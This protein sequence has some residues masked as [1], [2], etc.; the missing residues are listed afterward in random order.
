MQFS[1]SCSHTIIDIL[2][3]A[4]GDIIMRKLIKYFLSKLGLLQVASKLRAVVVGFYD[5]FRFSFRYRRVIH[6]LKKREGRK[7]RVLFVVN[8]I[9]KWKCQALFEIMK[10]SESYEPII[11]LSA[12]NE[13]GML[14]DAEIEK[15]FKRAESFFAELGDTCIRTVSLFPRVY[16][17][18][19]E[20]NTD[21]VFY[22]EPWAPCPGQT[23]MEVSQ[24]AL[25]FYIPYY[26]PNY[27]NVKFDCHD[28]VQ[29]FCFAFI[30][31]NV[32]WKNCYESSFGMFG[33]VCKFLPFG[34]P[35]MDLIARTNVRFKSIGRVIY[36]PHFSFPMEGYPLT[37]T[38]SSFKWSGQYML[39]YAKLHPEQNWVF[40]PH[41]SL[42]RRLQVTGY[43]TKDQ[44]DAYYG[45]WNKIGSIC[46]DGAYHKLFAESSV[47]ITDS[48]SFLTEYGAT[49]KPLIR[50][51]DSN[52]NTPVLAPSK[53]LY[54]TY[55]EAHNLDELK[56][57]L[58][59]ILDDKL[60]PKKEIRTIAALRANLLTAD[61]SRTI[62]NYID[63][64]IK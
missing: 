7:V 53:K 61:A 42:R 36:A 58:S 46:M 30:T 26:V 21:I 23:P 17:R 59:M 56:R 43:M 25:T 49:G 41:P 10:K 54:D 11:A 35:A 45:E 9:A 27:G 64:L 5:L 47:M 37:F 12:W 2:R 55:Y 48:A 13:I 44:I 16:H 29:R 52:N 34:H 20:F 63:N 62:V 32:A 19:E 38:F 24:N 14:T 6:R 33:H 39:E 1:L 4:L 60:D 3:L 8:E 15:V 31:L 50:L 40:K 57:V 28:P 51:I 18:L 22:S